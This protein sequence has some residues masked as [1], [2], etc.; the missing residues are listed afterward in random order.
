MIQDSVYNIKKIVLI[1][2]TACNFN[3]IYCIQHENKP[4]CK[5]QIKQEVL[6]WL[7]DIA[8]QLPYKFKPTIHF[9]GG[10]PLL[11]REA[12]HQ[13]VEHC[14]DNFNYLISSNGSY[15]TDEDVEFFN[16]N[17]IKFVLSNDGPNTKVTRQV[18]M[19]D[20]AEFVARF[21]KINDRGV[22]GVISALNQDYY[23]FFDHVEKY[24]PGCSISNEELVCGEST[25]PRLP[26]FDAETLLK[27]YKRMG[28]EL[29]ATWTGA[30]NTR[31]SDTF[32]Q[33][34]KQALFFI[35][36]P[37][38]PAF[39]VCGSGKSVI[40]VDTEGN[41]Y[42]CKNFN[43]KVGT[44]KDEYEVLYARAKHETKKLRDAHLEAKGCFGCPAF[45]FCRGGCPF[46][47]PSAAQKLKCNMTRTKWASVVSFIDNKLEIKDENSSN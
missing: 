35:N 16:A 27:S 30:E 18:D 46:E 12:I 14:R 43:V 21:N 29:E 7:D 47:K 33:Y 36:H 28:D 38:F 32:N 8:Y 41:V 44:V 15:L 20:D 10:E 4:R 25:D 13:V 40:N 34:L 11:Y 42:L 39:G 26:C 37:E 22:D 3:C 2:G 6:D 45:F 1:L 17:K 19:L 31:G 23:A 5:K 24:S 9:Y